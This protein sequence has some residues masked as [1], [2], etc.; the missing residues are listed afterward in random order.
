VRL[1]KILSYTLNP[2]YCRRCTYFLVTAFHLFLWHPSV[3]LFFRREGLRWLFI[4]LFSASLAAIITPAM[5]YLAINIKALDYPTKR[6]SHREATPILGGVAIYISFVGSLLKNFV[7]DSDTKIIL[8]C[9]TIVFIISL[10]DDIKQVSSWLRLLAQFLATSI[11]I[12]SG[13]VLVIFPRNTLWGLILNI[14][15]TFLWIIGISNAFN[16]FDGMDGLVAGLGIITAFFLGI[17]AFQTHQPYL[18]W[19][20]V[21]TLGSCLGFL[22]YNFKLRSNAEIFLGDS[23]SIFLGFILAAF[24]VKGEWSENNPIVSLSAPLLIFAILIYDMIHITVSRIARKKIHGF[25]DWI[26]YVGHDHMHHRFEALFRSKKMSVLFIYLISIC[27]GSLA[28]LLRYVDTPNAIL[29]LLQALIILILIT[30]L[31]STANKYQRR[32]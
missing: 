8:L 6:K 2:R 10:I 30:L 14:I 16:F 28:L 32:K 7:L 24:A 29:I 21:A 22:P 5:K 18:G 17:V 15:L 23:G 9:S 1:L 11:L 4:F 13:I 19:L 3:D 12:Y 31:E 20:A 27:L 26:N 25:L